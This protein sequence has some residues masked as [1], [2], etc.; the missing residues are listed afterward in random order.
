MTTLI[1]RNGELTGDR[2]YGIPALNGNNIFID[3]P[4]VHVHES[5]QVAFGICG[6]TKDRGSEAII[7]DIILANMIQRAKG[8]EVDWMPLVKKYMGSGNTLIVIT[9]TEAIAICNNE[10]GESYTLVNLAD[11]PFFTVGSGQ[12]AAIG[13]LIMNTDI[14]K[15]YQIVSRVDG[16]TG[17]SFDSILQKKLLKLRVGK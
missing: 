3:H 16:M 17:I 5:R 8:N 7:G 15:I 11:L 6:D 4:K 2:R 9:K 1:F 10:D 13:L 14:N 12:N